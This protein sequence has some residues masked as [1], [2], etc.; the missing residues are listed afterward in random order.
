[1]TEPDGTRFIYNDGYLDDMYANSVV[2]AWTVRASDECNQVFFLALDK[3]FDSSEPDNG[4]DCANRD[5]LAVENSRD[6]YCGGA[7]ANQCAS[8]RNCLGVFQIA[9]LSMIF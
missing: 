2:C 8:G 3:D 9:R 6:S 1:M 7:S 5:N 4:E